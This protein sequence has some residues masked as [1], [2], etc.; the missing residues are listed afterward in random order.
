MTIVTVL[1]IPEGIILASDTQT[2]IYQINAS[3][4]PIPINDFKNAQKIFEISP[5]NGP[6][7]AALSQFGIANPAGKPLSSHIFSIRNILKEEL[8]NL[9]TVDSI[10][11]KIITYFRQFPNNE[12]VGLG[13]FLSGFD[14][15]E[16]AYSARVLF[17][18]FT[19]NKE[20]EFKV[21]K[22]ISIKKGTFTIAWAGEGG[23]IINKLLNLSDEAGK[24]PRASIPYNVLSL[25]DGVEL[26]HY[27]IN[28]VIGFERFQ[29]RYPQCGGKVKIAVLTPFKF[30]FLN[31]Q[32]E[33]LYI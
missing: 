3:Q 2:T 27:F 29:S 28:T 11:D 31:V 12:L 30:K 25:K 18:S 10:A 1:S 4:Q 17:I 24:I 22:S 32:E 19:I 14:F 26:S 20:K 21:D 7:I 5:E 23:W 15:E 8:G 33:E 16:G 6:V 9:T 13:F